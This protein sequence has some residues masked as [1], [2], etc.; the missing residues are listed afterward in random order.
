MLWGSAGDM[1]AFGIQPNRELG[2]LEIQNMK[3]GSAHKLSIVLL[4]RTGRPSGEEILKKLVSAQKEIVGVLAEKRTRIL[5]NQ[6]RHA[7]AH[8]LY[9]SARPILEGEAAQG[10]RISGFGPCPEE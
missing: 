8:A 2:L 5:L 10:T 1:F 6:E 9:E 4:T 3:N 7:E